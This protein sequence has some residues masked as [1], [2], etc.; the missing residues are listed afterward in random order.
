ML[1]WLKVSELGKRWQ[2][3]KGKME[4]VQIWSKAWLLYFA[5]ADSMLTVAVNL[6]L[7]PQFIFLPYLADGAG[8]VELK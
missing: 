2:R 5:M 4:L 1:S 7:L 8:I 6:G 3:G